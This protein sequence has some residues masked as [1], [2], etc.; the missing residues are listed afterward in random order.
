MRVVLSCGVF[1]VVG[2]IALLLYVS[3][4]NALGPKVILFVY[5]LHYTCLQSASLIK[6]LAFET[7]KAKADSSGSN[8][9]LNRVKEKSDNTT[10]SGFVSSDFSDSKDMYIIDSREHDFDDEDI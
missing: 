1:Y 9:S 5:W 3:P 4:A 7:P 6:I 2:V 8:T 10:S